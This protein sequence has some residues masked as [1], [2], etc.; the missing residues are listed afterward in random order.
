M[1]TDAVL[2]ALFQPSQISCLIIHLDVIICPT[3]PLIILP[4]VLPSPSKAVIG[5]KVMII[6]NPRSRNA[7]EGERRRG[8]RGE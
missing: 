4:P 6:V 1:L 7:K 8:K 2:P 3:Q 5:R